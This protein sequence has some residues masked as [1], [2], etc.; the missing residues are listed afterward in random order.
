[1]LPTLRA[2]PATSPSPGIWLQSLGGASA[3][4]T[5]FAE[6]AKATNRLTA[7]TEGQG[8]EGEGS[9][10]SKKSSGK[11]RQFRKSTEVDALRH[12]SEM[13]AT[14]AAQAEAHA[15]DELLAQSIKTAELA[16]LVEEVGGQSYPH[17][18]RLMATFRR[19]PLS[20]RLRST[21]SSST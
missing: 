14:L 8:E 10:A 6:F 16:T 15:R 1:M 9:G 21:P 4:T 20:T 17:T 12:E 2:V 5:R 11:R 18:A 7:Q 3:T 13:A 19:S